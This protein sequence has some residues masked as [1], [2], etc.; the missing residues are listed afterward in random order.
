MS[1]QAWR[2]RGFTDLVSIVPPDAPLSATTSIKPQTRGKVPGR[3]GADGL[4]SGY[5]FNRLVPDAATLRAW[6]DAGAGVGLRTRHFPAVDIDVTD[7][8]WADEVHGIASRVLGYAPA[9]TGRAPKR[10][11]LYRTDAPFK[12]QRLWIRREGMFAE[13]KHL[14]EV[15]G[16]G[17]QFVVEGI[18]PG[19]GQPF[20]W[21]GP[22]AHPGELT[23]ITLAQVDA[24]LAEVAAE[25][26]EAG[27]TCEREGKVELAG[28]R[29]APPQPQL[30]APSTETLE[31]TLAAIPN[32]SERFPGR[33]DY[34]TVG[35][36][37]KAAGG[38][39]DHWWSWCARWDQPAD[40]DT[41]EADWKRLHPPF[42]VGFPYLQDLARDAGDMSSVTALFEAEDPPVVAEAKPEKPKDT[43]A[44]KYSDAWVA[45]RVIA[46]YGIWIK[47]C[48]PLGGWMAWTGT[49]WEPDTR[50][51]VPRWVAAV[52][53]E[54]GFEASVDVKEFSAKE[55]RAEA[56]RLASARTLK[57][58]LEYL[59]HHAKI[60]IDQAQFDADPWALNTPAGIVD[61][62][63]GVI[64]PSDPDRLC[65]RCTA[66][67]PGALESA[68]RWRAF[69]REA[70]GGDREVEGYLRRLAG[71]ALTGSTREHSC[72]FLYGPGGNGKGTFLNTLTRAFGTYADVA[73]ME[74]FAA[75]KGDK[76]PADLAS[77]VGRRLVTAQ[78]TQE[79]RAWDESRLKAATGG[80]PI[81]ARFLFGQPFTFKPQFTLVFAGNH[82]PTIL[83]LD[84]AW[85]RRLHMVPFTM[86][87]A[88]MDDRLDEVLQAELAGI[89]GWAIGGCQEW[90]LLGLSPPT[91]ILSYTEE[92]F[93]SQDPLGQWMED[94]VTFDPQ[95]KDVVTVQAM[96]AD[97]RQWCGLQGEHPGTIRRFQQSVG[98]RGLKRW[99][100]EQSGER[101]FVG[102]RLPEGK[103]VF[104]VSEAPVPAAMSVTIH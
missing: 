11:L 22:V 80:D 45:A 84:A 28:E 19:T 66:V 16:D 41:A 74:T 57:A 29:V 91:S 21:D 40:Q 83:N 14:I 70:T 61:L 39:F 99:R 6:D 103:A 32:T 44:A 9:R 94:R 78:E 31:T 17:Q 1:H 92:Y 12:K 62:R 85:R 87:P 23:R 75:A 43:G 38:T 27:W 3:R 55:S 13:E 8:A 93:E 51:A 90:Q 96:Y 10:T 26:T 69:L 7:E 76:H 46:Q 65:T 71:Y 24:F 2:Q 37:V 68:P 18:H 50:G 79:G 86:R 54:V 25:F 59:Q 35:A 53:R 58:V 48:K 20:A 98:S 73:A 81:K 60:A 102:V 77:L 88:R 49:T 56:K 82:R 4:W 101:G 72:T 15:L 100:D 104:H 5:D 42:A 52:C 89:L 95:A 47:F 34:L 63:S 36:A 67:G 33:Q 97:W 30:L 64:E